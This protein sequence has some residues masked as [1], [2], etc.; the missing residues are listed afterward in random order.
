MNA[1]RLSSRTPLALV[2]ILTLALGACGKK[3]D[4]VQVP[5]PVFAQRYVPPPAP[6]PDPYPAQ[7]AAPEAPDLASSEL[8][9]Q[10]VGPI[11]GSAEDFI[12]TAGDRVF[13]DYDRSI[14]TADAKRTLDRQVEWLLRYPTVQV[15][16]EGNTD[17]R[18]T[19]P[20]NL[21]LGQRRANAVRAYM[22]SRSLPMSRMTT[23]SNGLMQ[24]IAL[25]KDPDSYARNRNAQTIVISAG[26][27]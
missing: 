15:R 7:P 10:S 25:G 18:G 6:A 2:V 22:A 20:Y 26:T 4:W 5:G 21:G 3:Y 1:S 17:E 14:L 13:F 23:V 12:A 24:P 11:P 27:R 8:P 16:I 19:A 9:A